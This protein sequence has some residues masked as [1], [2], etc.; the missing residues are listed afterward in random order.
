MQ[1]TKNHLRILSESINYILMYMSVDEIIFWL[2]LELI[3]GQSTKVFGS[4]EKPALLSIYDQTRTQVIKF[5]SWI[6]KSQGDS[7]AKVH[8]PSWPMWP[9][10]PKFQFI[11]IIAQFLDILVC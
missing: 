9:W 10:D 1:V 6:K 11:R 5:M 4:S 2:I 8:D 3:K 7:S